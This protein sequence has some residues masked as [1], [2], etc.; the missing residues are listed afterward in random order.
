MGV[1]ERVLKAN[2]TWKKQKLIASRE[3]VKWRIWSIFLEQ[4]HLLM[5]SRTSGHKASLLRQQSPPLPL[6]PFSS[7]L[8]Q[9]RALISSLQNPK[10]THPSRNPQFLSTRPPKHSRTRRR[11]IYQILPPTSLNQSPEKKAP[12]PSTLPETNS[13]CT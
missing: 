7:K 1:S 8:V 4:L 11:Q 2:R 6:P 9:K 10:C 12:H 5:V 13:G 3:V